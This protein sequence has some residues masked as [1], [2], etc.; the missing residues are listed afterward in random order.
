MPVMK[1]LALL[2]LL[3]AACS[4]SE[5]AAP[6]PASGTPG[7]IRGRIDVTP[8]LKANVTPGHVIYVSARKGGAPGPPI[9]AK[10]LAM[11]DFPIAF[12][13]TK[14]DVM[15]QGAAALEGEVELTVRI[16]ADGDPMTRQPGDLVWKGPATTGGGD[17]T[18]LI[19]EALP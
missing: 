2:I 16:D 18:V 8:A 14:D 4:K 6:T 12:E 7:V 17:V 9:A 15:M 5:Q 13:L 3:L 1:R 10:K 11:A 19:A